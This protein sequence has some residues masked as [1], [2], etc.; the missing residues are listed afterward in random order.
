MTTT[1]RPMSRRVL[2]AVLLAALLALGALVLVPGLARM[3]P[4]GALAGPPPPASLPEC[5]VDDIPAERTGSDDWAETLLD[6]ARTLGSDYVPPDLVTAD[7][8]GRDV[9]LRSFVVPELGEMIDAARADGVAISVTSG[10]RSHRQQSALFR[11]LAAEHGVGQAALSVARAGHS[12]HQLG[13][14]VDL[15]GGADWL[16]QHAWRFGFA[17]SY[18]AG[19]SPAWSCYMPESWHYRYFGRDRAAEIQRSGLSPREWLWL[20]AGGA[21]HDNRAAGH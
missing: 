4:L 8:A 18:P 2:H 11:E 19:R 7:V 1:T 15:K 20:R 10:Y 12:E 6:T 17:Q 5:R 21:E 9:E 13:T 14:A 3:G 16:R